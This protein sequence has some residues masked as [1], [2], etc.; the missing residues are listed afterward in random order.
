M[1]PLDMADDDTE[2]ARLTA[3]PLVGD[4]IDAWKARMCYTVFILTVIMPA[5][6]RTNMTYLLLAVCM[7][8]CVMSP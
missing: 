2:T 6:P 1:A 4:K 5:P 7:C 8:V 3:L